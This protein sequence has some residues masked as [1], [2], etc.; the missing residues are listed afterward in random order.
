MKKLY[1]NNKK[2]VFFVQH[3]FCL[4]IRKEKNLVY[5]VKALIKFFNDEKKNRESMVQLNFSD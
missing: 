3:F 2:T 5:I 1:K 4:K